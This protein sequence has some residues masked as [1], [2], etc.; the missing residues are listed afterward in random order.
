M[1]EE[2][3]FM[4]PEDLGVGL[5][6]VLKYIRES[7]ITSQDELVGRSLDKKPKQADSG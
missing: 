5:S 2:V 3:S 6:G 1:K 7:G 4:H